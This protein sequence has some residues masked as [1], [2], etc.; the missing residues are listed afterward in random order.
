M[1]KPI[2]RADIEKAIIKTAQQ[3]DKAEKG[4]GLL[5]ALDK[6]DSQFRSGTAHPPRFMPG[7]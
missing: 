7:A 3:V 5:R 6:V 2:S 4:A 1:Q